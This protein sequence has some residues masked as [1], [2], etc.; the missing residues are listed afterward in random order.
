MQHQ[1]FEDRLSESQLEPSFYRQ[2]VGRIAMK[3][4]EF[5]PE[6]MIWSYMTE[7]YSEK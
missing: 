1:D 5:L 6:E 7:Y 2:K 3:S 4:G